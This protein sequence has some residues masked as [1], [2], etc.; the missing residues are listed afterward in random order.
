M[1]RSTYRWSYVLLLAALVAGFILRTHHLVSNPQGIHPDEA[2]Y[3]YEGWSI[4]DTGCD[5][6]LTGCPPLY[7]KGYST[8]WDNRT[9]V[10]YP[11]IYSVLFRFLPMTLL[12]VRLLSVVLGMAV[13]IL[14]FALGR[15]LWPLRSTVAGWAAVFVALS[16][17]AVG[18]SKL[19]HDPITVPF[20]VLSI[21]VSV[22]MTRRHPLW[23]LVAALCLALG[24]YAYQPF[25]FVGPSVF[26]LS[27]WYVRP[28]WS[29]RQLIWCIGAAMFGLMLSIPFVVNQLVNWNVVQRQFNSMI[30]FRFE[31]SWFSVFK[32]VVLYVWNM[33]GN[34]GLFLTFILPAA[35]LGGV[36]LFR[37]DRRRAMLL[38]G[39]VLA[40]W[41]P[42]FI[43]FWTSGSNEMQSRGLGY[44]G[45]LELLAAFGLGAFFTWLWRHTQA[46]QRGLVMGLIVAL[47][48]GQVTVSGLMNRSWGQF[49]CFV[50]GGMEDVATFVNQPAYADRTVVINFFHFMQGVNMLWNM[51][52]DPRIA[53]SP[54]TRF[55]RTTPDD[56]K[57]TQFPSRVGRFRL[58]TIEDCFRPGDG[59]LY[60]VHESQLP[61][62]P[63]VA[64]FKLHFMRQVFTWKVVDN[65]PLAVR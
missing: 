29:R 18:W 61:G 43:T 31:H 23:W 48:A 1:I 33:I 65:R 37:A 58:C 39:W 57:E 63:I 35:V 59:A 42:V 40:A 50:L 32:N 62:L 3:G 56:P 10:L 2:L 38:I 34:P 4:R 55:T 9:S 5:Y 49:C 51:R 8:S 36:L 13:I 64:T 46:V 52:I 20:F 25:K 53:Q 15:L 6:R 16:P 54:D 28:R 19:G 21:G 24:F 17:V 12:T 30:L 11:Y 26:L 41:L 45:A 44:L 7:L 27:C 22:L 60:V 47:F 14:T